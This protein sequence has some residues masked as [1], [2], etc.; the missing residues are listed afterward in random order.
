MTPERWEQIAAVYHAA[1]EH[2]PGLRTNY[3]STACGQDDELR[4][5]V[6][7]LLAHGE[8]AED[9]LSTPVGGSGQRRAGPSLEPGSRLGDYR[10]LA[11]LG[12]GG[13]GEVYRAEDPHLGRDIAIKILPPQWFGDS[14]RR[15]RFEREARLLASLNHPHIGAIYGVVEQDGVRGLVLELVDGET[16]AAKLT[17][18]PL[19]IEVAI[20]IAGQVADALD[21]SHQKGIIHRDLKPG[22]IIVR[23]D[24]VAPADRSASGASGAQ[25]RAARPPVLTVKVLD[26]GLARAGDPGDATLSEGAI[27]SD[28]PTHDGAVMGTAPYM[29]PEQA[30]GK[31][32]DK[33]A[34]IWA[35]GCVLYEMLAGRRPFIGETTVDTMALILEHD[36]DW[37][38]LPEGLPP[39]VRRLVQRC[40]EKDLTLRLRD[41]GDARFDL[42][43]ARRDADEN[44]LDPRPRGPVAGRAP[45][46]KLAATVGVAILVATAMF[47]TR[48]PGPVLGW[49]SRAAGLWGQ[50]A[51]PGPTGS[52]QPALTRLT[53]DP[54]LQTDPAI[55]PDGQFV[56]Y[57][58][59]TSGNFDIWVRAVAGGN[60]IQITTDPAHDWQPHWSPDGHRLVFRSE[61]RGGGLFIVPAFGGAEERVSTIGFR[62]RWSPDGARILF[63]RT[64]AGRF[65]TTLNTVVPGAEPMVHDLS[66]ALPI[67][68]GRAWGWTPDNRV[69]LM[70]SEDAPSFT[71]RLSVLT[72]DT[73]EWEHAE[74]DPRVQRA[75]Q[76]LRLVVQRAPLAWADG[77]AAVYFVGQSQGLNDVWRIGVEPQSRRVVSGPTR[78]TTSGDSTSAPTVSRDG[79]AMVFGVSRSET[80]IWS[81]GL[82][83][84]GT[85]VGGPAEALTATTTIA[86]NLHLSADG[87]KLVYIVEQPGGSQR[88]E[89]RERRMVDGRERTLMRVDE[90]NGEI[91]G[92]LRWSPDGRV[93]AYR[94]VPPGSGVE[95][96]TGVSRVF[97]LQSLRLRNVDTEKDSQLTSPQQVLDFPND[98]SRDGKFVLTSGNRYSTDGHATLAMV[99]IA[100]APHAESGARVIVEAAD[101]AARLYQPGLSPDGRW[102]CFVQSTES[103]SQVKVAPV[104]G[105]R[106]THV[107]AGAA[108][109]DKPRWSVNGRLLY[110]TSRRGGLNNV[111]GI[112]FDPASG[113]TIGDAFKVT[114]KFDG[115]GETLPQRQGEGD[116]GVADG[117]LVVPVL[118]TQGAVWLLRN[119]VQ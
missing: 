99:P 56:A 92:P 88:R 98:W 34:D 107:A 119:F 114:T 72:L 78:V 32:V 51:L 3:L 14:V 42:D 43:M 26:F 22:N 75:F 2:A 40:L 104:D 46:R 58:A 27:I 84:S 11:A 38:V 16:L 47:L 33:R 66:A 1:L 49:A 7:S 50:R 64:D 112:R 67:E 45:Y 76:D 108:V 12:I 73:K 52:P 19:P 5:E 77:A 57:T 70:S 91:R 61:R 74:V 63:D 35:F 117:R 53:F 97:A 71:L 101:P 65:A 41:I 109:D 59:D 110:F 9:F 21:A 111:W 113:N 89:V 29:S 96:S 39:V 8:Q 55:S 85:A 62:P 105:G 13:M 30:R 68:R 24:W 106:W 4:R 36:P 83:A 28:D 10:I 90:A 25:R 86:S 95:Q 94:Y 37:T 100:R 31:P 18:G 93:L 69:A 82:T 23:G 60:A 81:L 20:E 103:G 6:E 79:Q 44:R 48:G 15:T 54:G 80:R 87:S 116:F 115:P 102:L 17:S 118:K